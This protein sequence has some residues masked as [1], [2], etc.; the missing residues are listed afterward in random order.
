MPQFY[1]YVYLDPSR[2]FQEIYV[3]KGSGKRVYEHLKNRD[4]PKATENK[5]FMGRL[6]NMKIAGIEPVIQIFNCESEELALLAE[7]EAIDKYG[8][9]DLGKGSLFNHTN[10]GEG[11]SNP[12][13]EARKKMSNQRR[14]LATWMK[15]KTHTDEAKRQNAEAHLG[16]KFS[17]EHKAKIAK[18]VSGIVRSAETRLKIAE[19]VKNRPVLKCPHC[20]KE[21]NA[22]NMKFWHFDNCKYKK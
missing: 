19:A 11:V 2:N 1:M 14:G 5:Q 8:R 18:G 9:A 4:K 10:G 15:G 13:D 3:G 21:S 17:D 12:S 7:E 22:A 16:K 6:R 20:A